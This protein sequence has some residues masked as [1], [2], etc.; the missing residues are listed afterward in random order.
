MILQTTFF[1]KNSETNSGF[2]LSG[3]NSESAF[4][5]MELLHAAELMKKLISGVPGS[6]QA[7]MS[8]QA[9]FLQWLSH[10]SVLFLSFTSCQYFHSCQKWIKPYLFSNNGMRSLRKSASFL[11]RSQGETFLSTD[12]KTV[13]SDIFTLSSCGRTSEN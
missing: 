13:P 9:A 2:I 12:L 11:L 4:L 8:L 7:Q 5:E 6:W 3:K 1:F 10:F